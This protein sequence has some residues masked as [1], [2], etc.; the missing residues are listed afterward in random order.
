MDK[1][2]KRYENGK[3]YT[4]RCRYDDDLIYV[5]S[6]IQKLCM[7]MA[8][9]RRDKKCSLYQYVNGDWDNWYIELYEE[10]PCNNKS[11]LEKREGEVIRLIGNIN[12]QITGRT[13]KE[14]YEDNF[15]KIK[16]Q[17]KQYQQNNANKIAEQRKQYQQN[18]ANKIA[19]YNKQYRQ[20]NSDKIAEWHKEHY[21][22]NRDEIL[23]QRKQY[24][25]ENADKIA[26]RKKQK[27]EC[28]KCKSIVC[29]GDL[30][31]HKKTIKCQE[32]KK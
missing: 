11:I 5:G 26:E 24:Q 23:E 32:H 9:H 8:G 7:R 15:D 17:Q 2:D 6:T 4:I 21:E 16:E 10:Y 22:T 28:D 1:I 3:I 30:A 19:E 20:Y 29:R 25:Q 27:I 12:K 31:K 13:R 18:N 14:W